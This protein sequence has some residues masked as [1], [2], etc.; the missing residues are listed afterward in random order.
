MHTDGHFCA[1]STIHCLLVLIFAATLLPT[2]AS[3]QEHQQPPLDHR[4]TRYLTHMPHRSGIV[5]R[6]LTVEQQEVPISPATPVRPSLAFT[7]ASM[8]SARRS[9]PPAPSRKPKSL[10]PFL[11]RIPM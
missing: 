8:S 3:G 9:L 6:T 1:S 2:P 7:R 11:R 4:A 10:Y 5:E